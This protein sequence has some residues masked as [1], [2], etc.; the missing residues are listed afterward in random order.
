MEMSDRLT[1]ERD[2]A[3]AALEEIRLDSKTYHRWTTNKFDGEREMVGCNYC[4]ASAEGQMPINH[5][6]MCVLNPEREK[7]FEEERAKRG[8]APR[9]ILKCKARANGTAG[10]NDPQECEYPNCGCVE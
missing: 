4:P 1:V 8:M 7:A 2:A 9:P 6:R 5:H 3:R 10:G